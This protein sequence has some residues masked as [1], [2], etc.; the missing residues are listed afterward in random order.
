MP[1]AQKKFDDAEI[2][3]Y[4]VSTLYTEGP[5]QKKFVE[6]IRSCRWYGPYE[7]SENKNC[8]IFVSLNDLGDN[9]YLVKLDLNFSKQSIIFSQ[10][11]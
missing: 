3:L 10:Q 8:F 2:N 7:N 6:Q 4:D 9:E 11:K 5:L 1:A